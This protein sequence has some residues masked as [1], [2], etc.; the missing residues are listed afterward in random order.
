MSDL[1][2]DHK[3][4][5]MQAAKLAKKNTKSGTT[6]KYLK[7]LGVRMLEKQQPKNNLLSI[8]LDSD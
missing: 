8:Y 5:A 4:I 6:P 3:T 2:Q 1:K 7:R